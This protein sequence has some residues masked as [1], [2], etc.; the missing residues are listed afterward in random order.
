MSTDI[1]LVKSAHTKTSYTK[2][3][4]A[5]LRKCF[6][7]V[8]GPEHFI[9]NYI[10]IQHPT[11]GRMQLKL[12]DY[13][14]GLLESYHTNRKNINLISRQ[15]GKSTVA[16]AYLL[17]YAMFVPDSTILV[18]SNKH[19]GALEIMQRIRFA[20]ES[21]PDYIRAGVVSYNK[22]SIDFDN[23]SR[24]ISQTT[25][26]NTG[27]GLSISLLYLDEFAF[28]RPNIA[29]DLW[30]SLSPTL[31][32]GGKCIITST[33]NSD[34]DMF[35]KLWNGAIDCYDAHGEQ[36][37]L[38]KNGFAS[39]LA[40]WE[41]HPERNDEWANRERSAIGEERFAREHEC[42]FVG[43][44]ETLIDQIVLATMHGVDPVRKT[45]NHVRWYKNID[46]AST[47][48]VALD[49]AIGTGGDNAAIQIL[50][51]PSLIQVGEWM[52][53]RTPIEGQIKILQ[54]ICKDLSSRGVEDL[55]WSVENNTIGEAALVVIREAG[56][57]NIPGFFLSD[58]DVKKLG[59]RRKGFNT[60]NRKK[61]EA[62]VKLKR[63]IDTSKMKVCSR[64]LITELKN[65][66]SVEGSYRA[67]TGL[68]DDLVSALLIAIRM[69]D[70]AAKWDPALQDA[71][72]SSIQFDDEDYDDEFDSSRM[73]MP[74]AIL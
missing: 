47:Y 29:E 42:R 11:K 60:T 36:T 74:I 20:Y 58:P 59:G 16:G 68:K 1:K 27:R 41:A 73:P 15:M 31:A 43:A 24:I 64:A 30:T 65:F 67:K 7:P 72:N 23:G 14:V 49:P 50:E 44:D 45:Q 32:T 6:D 66:I 37:K 28:V 21:I 2:E 35:A 53:N 70:V 61:L 22:K 39:Y 46:P 57:E 56:E 25:T 17:W 10:Y 4:L 54:S 71:L 9:T 12:Y 19:T 55:F 3:E 62:C 52:H 33:P 69:A 26:E 40:T 38:G 63:F 13:Q 51:L 5:E 34:E 8:T 18:A 48:I